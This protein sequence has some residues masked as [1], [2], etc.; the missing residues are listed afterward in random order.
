MKHSHKTALALLL[1][2]FSKDA[3][4]ASQPLSHE[5]GGL[6]ITSRRTRKTSTREVLLKIL[7]EQARR[8]P[9]CIIK[10]PEATRKPAE[11][12]TQTAP[13]LPVNRH[14]NFDAELSCDDVSSSLYS[15]LNNKPEASMVAPPLATLDY[16]LFEDDSPLASP[17]ASPNLEVGSLDKRIHDLE[18]MHA[19]LS[20]EK[21][22][23][24]LQ[25]EAMEAQIECIQNE[26]N[27]FE[28][29]NIDLG[30][31]QML[32][33]M[34]LSVTL[35]EMQKTAQDTFEKL[36]NLKKQM[37]QSRVSA[38]DLKRHIEHVP[39]SS[40][41]LHQNF[42]KRLTHIIQL[43]SILKQSVTPTMASKKT[44]RISFST[45]LASYVEAH[46]Y[47]ESVEK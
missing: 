41:Y 24:L 38:C 45:P 30:D 23:L 46:P 44:K 32:H 3:L 29:K 42:K 33:L 2:L 19:S 26:I 25:K 31:E 21:S 15:A 1:F 28:E 16:P 39:F 9:D 22:A 10:K 4:L 6:T 20:A 13:R 7:E 8:Y 14:I 12:L 27:D 43:P 35:E 5:E 34:T 18:E 37:A 17:H 47:G 11:H 36:E 40:P